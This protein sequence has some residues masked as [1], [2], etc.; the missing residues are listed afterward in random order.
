MSSKKDK[1]QIFFPI[2]CYSLRTFVQANRKHDLAIVLLTRQ[3]LTALLINFPPQNV[4]VS[5]KVF[6]KSICICS[7]PC[8]S[9]L[10]PFVNFFKQLNELLLEKYCVFNIFTSYLIKNMQSYKINNCQHFL[11]SKHAVSYSQYMSKQFLW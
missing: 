3:Y 2:G 5:G 4:Y 1:C 10:S 6:S 8:V 9:F 7:F 11:I